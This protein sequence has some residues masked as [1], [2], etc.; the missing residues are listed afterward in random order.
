MDMNMMNMDFGAHREKNT[1][2]IDAA[3]TRTILHAGLLS[4]ACFS[5]LP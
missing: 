5:P 2:K 4:N 1:K 3:W